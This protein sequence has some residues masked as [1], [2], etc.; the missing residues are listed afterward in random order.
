MKNIISFISLVLF[1]VFTLKAQVSGSPQISENSGDALE[2][3]FIATQSQLD[4]LENN[5]EYQSNKINFID[6]YKAKTFNRSS[7]TTQRTQVRT[8]CIA[9][10]VFDGFCY[11][12]V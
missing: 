4:N 3:G 7:R 9:N 11:I 8:Y 2:C 6:E 5:P 1:T 12:L 10:Y